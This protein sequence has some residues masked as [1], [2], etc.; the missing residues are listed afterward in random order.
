ML[1][2]LKAN[3]DD[4]PVAW[5]RNWSHDAPGTPLTVVE[6][7]REMQRH[8]ECLLEDCPRKANAFAVLVSAGRVKP[9]SSRRGVPDDQETE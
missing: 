6:A 4:R 9:D 2:L 7:H 5:T 1:A 3:P 8:R